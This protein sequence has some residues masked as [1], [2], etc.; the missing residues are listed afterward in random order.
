MLILA[1]VLALALCGAASAATDKEK[2]NKTTEENITDNITTYSGGDPIINGTV[3]VNEY[4]HVRP[5]EGASVIVNSTSGNV[6][7]TTTTDANGYYYV[8]FFSTETQFN[9]KV[10]YTGCAPITQSVTVTQGPNYP[11]DP[12]YYGTSNF[13]L[14]PKTATLTGTGNG[15]NVYIQ[16]KNEN[17]FAGVINVRV[18]GVT[19]TAYCIDLFTPISIGDTLLVNGPLPGTAGDL[20]SEVDWSKVTY[21]L[22]NYNPSTSSNEAAAIQCAIWYFTSVHYGPYGGPNPIPGY[23]QFMT[24]PYDGLVSG[25][26]TVR[27]RALQIIGQAIAM[28]YPYSI[29]VTPETI[30]W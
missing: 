28:N 26:Y 19:Y 7:A 6:L 4:G 14:T 18:D 24:A 23:Y 20:P 15:R 21:I 27:N 8:N 25:D 10:S 12:N 2:K 9:V 17:G 22:N 13:T 29:N 11:T 16:G 30:V 3:T 5:L 1:L